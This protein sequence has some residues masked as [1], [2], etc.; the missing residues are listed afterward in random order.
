MSKSKGNGVNPMDLIDMYGAD[1]MR[2]NLLTL[3]TN[4]QD[5]KFDADID[6][7]TKAL[8]G[9]A[10][11]EQAR[12]FVTKI[13][14][15]SRFLLMNMDGYTPGEPVAET[16]ADAWMFS[17]LAKAVRMVTEGIEQYTFGEMARGVQNF[18]WNEVCDWY[19]E[20]T[21]TH[22]KDDDARLQ[23]QRNLIFVLDTSLRLMHPLM[24]F[25]TEAIWTPCPPAGSIWPRT[26]RATA[27]RP[28]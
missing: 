20:V 25:V 8:K 1:A 22:L 14:N 26:A 10:R 6:K 17:R 2:F 15:A 13:W 19:V 24:P 16:A 27:P 11:T 3:C 18:F 5:V 28:S 4:N 23:A 12:A 7:K 9:S 21:E